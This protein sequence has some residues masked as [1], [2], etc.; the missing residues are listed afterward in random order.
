MNFEPFA[1]ASANSRCTLPCSAYI[2]FGVLQ[3]PRQTVI[4]PSS[5]PLATRAAQRWTKAVFLSSQLCFWA[6]VDERCAE[7]IGGGRRGPAPADPRNCRLLPT[8]RHT[9]LWRA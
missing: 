9:R 8:P 1:L 2:I 3:T 5:A 6:G 4:R 7:A